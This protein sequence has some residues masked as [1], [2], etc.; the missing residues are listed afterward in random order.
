MR[1]IVLLGLVLAGLT[2]PTAVAVSNH[3]A[4]GRELT[5]ARTPGQASYDV[6]LTANATGVTWTGREKI[7]FTNTGDSPLREVYLRLWGNTWDGCKAPVKLSRFE[8]GTAA[9]PTV[10]CTAQKI[11]L[12][13]PLRPGQRSAV[14]FDLTLTAPQRAERFGRSGKY[15]FFGNALPV[16]AVRD[17]AGWHLEPDVGIGESYYTLAADFTVRL[18]HPAGLAV[19]ATGTSTT[20]RGTT[21][22]KAKQVRDFAWA[23]GPFKQATTKSP[24]GITIRTAWTDV[25]TAA[26]VKDAQTRA[27]AA[28]DDFGRRFGTYPYGEVDLVLNDNWESFYGMEYPGFVLLIAPPNEEGPVVH[29]LAHQWF[30][31]I[32]GNN[33]YADPWLDESFAV[34]ASYIHTGDNQ[35]DCW[36]GRLDHLITSDMGHWKTVPGWSAY[37]YS[38]GACMLHDLERTLGTKPMAAMLKA[39]TKANWYGVATPRAF[40]AAAQAATTKDLTQF[41]KDH[42]IG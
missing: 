7:S 6:R 23:A 11:T 37:V 8:G 4:D 28:I 35:P 19:P 24:G 14:A 22:S 34:Y 9:A 32:V 40:K 30:Y 39:Y 18:D 36:P 38:Y 27:A 21:I 33:E 25:V 20:S 41:W 3:S 2:A 26:A 16:L 29:E 17:Q 5:A 13:K 12:T 15:S 10:N 1:R 31:G 42:A